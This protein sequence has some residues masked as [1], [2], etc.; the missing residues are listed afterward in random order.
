MRFLARCCLLLLVP[1][2]LDAQGAAPGM[3]TIGRADSI[4]SPTLKETRRYLIYTPASYTQSPYQQH[5]Y[6][7][8]YLL[9][10]DGHFH[11]MTGVIQFLS[12]GMNGTYVVPEMIVVAIPNTDRTRDL[13]PTKAPLGAD[14]KLA[15][16]Y[17]TSGGG[18]EFLKFLKSEL[19]PHIDSTLRTE[20]YR[21]LV[22]HSLGGIT[23]IDALYT[24]PDVFNAYVA[25]DPSLWYDNQVLLKKAKDYF[26]Q[27]APP[28]RALFVA[29]ANT[30]VAGDTAPS[31]HFR[32]I[33]E[34]VRVVESGNRSGIRYAYKYYGNDDHGSVPSMA[35]YDALRFI[36]DGYKLDVRKSV[37]QPA[38]ISTHFDSVSKRL[39]YRVRPPEKLV[40][41]IAPLDSSSTV[42]LL[43]LNTEQYPNSAHAF[44]VLGTALLARR[45][46]A[47]ARSALGRALELDP[48][49]QPAKDALARL[50]GA[51]GGPRE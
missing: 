22:G 3:I 37:R 38:L 11:S 48:K 43:R 21:V 6:P 13:T 39:G 10:G 19:I 28:A 9:D 34:F 30:L 26:S 35:E 31:T 15:P 51:S 50:S 16:F 29:H 20:P 12:T 33:G 5:R 36:F 2:A 18:K 49:N 23:T 41:R 25:I 1:A 8:L 40:D 42:A 27:P 47:S 45:D 17:A 46:T 32:S 7:V 24:M 44:Q 4:W 14:G